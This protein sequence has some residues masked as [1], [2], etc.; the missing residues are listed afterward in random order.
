MDV[1]LTQTLILIKIKKHT[2]PI[3]KIYHSSR[4]FEVDN[5]R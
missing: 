3:K 2:K 1:K 4:F 5:K